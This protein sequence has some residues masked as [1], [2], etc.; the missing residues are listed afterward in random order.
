MLIIASLFTLGGAETPKLSL[1]PPSFDGDV[2]YADLQTIV[3]DYPQRVAGSDPDSRMAIWVEQRLASMGLETHIDS[4]AATVD[5]RDAALQNIWA[6]SRGRTQGTI[7]IV[8]ARDVSPLATQGAGDNASG[9]AALLALAQAFT[10]AAH[11]HSIIFLCT[12]GDTYGA[13]GAR[14]FCELHPTDDLYAVFALRDVAK[15]NPSGIGIDGWSPVAKTAPPWL[16]LLT[17]PTARRDAAMEAK[18]PTFAAQVLR[19]AVPTGAGSQGPFVARGVPAVTISAAGPTVPAQRD[20]IDTISKETLTKIGAT[21][22]SM[23]LAV[24]GSTGPGAPSGG[25]VF[26]THRATLPGGGL[27]VMIAA[28]LIPLAAAT[29]ELLVRSRRR[30]AP[31][32]PALLRAGTH[33]APWILLVIIVYLANLVGLLPRSPDAVIP[34]DS[35]LAAT[36][37]YLRVVVLAILLAAAYLYALAVTRRFQRRVVVDPA[38]T[39]FIAHAALLVVA[40]LLLTI[41]PYSVLLVLPAAILWPLARPGKWTDWALPVYLGLLM[42]PVV[43]L[44]HA[45]ELDLGWKVWWYFFLLFENGTIPTAAVLIAVV[46]FSSVALLTQAFRHPEAGDVFLPPVRRKRRAPDQDGGETVTIDL[47]P[48]R[49]EPRPRRLDETSPPHR[50]P[51]PAS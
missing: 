33:L 8:A 3:E 9:V 36:P 18:L 16:W 5:G 22:Q 38:A 4:F 39:L 47:R 51:P 23:V 13:L 12:T 7:L 29:F 45:L 49:L 41:N 6:I 26:L 15:Q 44:Y 35:P 50:P 27:S 42:I 48:R 32:K 34:P 30:R 37:Q 10:V 43:L 1:E 28:A 21:V 20:T 14:T 24:D 46:F 2:A 40:G 25:T 19:L 17:T 31:L 11:D